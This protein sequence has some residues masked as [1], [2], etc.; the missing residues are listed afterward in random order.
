MKE[1]ISKN[2][3]PIAIVVAG[4]LVAVACFL[5]VQ[6]NPTTGEVDN[7][8]SLIQTEILSETAYSDQELEDLAKCLTESGAKFYGASWCGWCNKEKELFGQAVQYLPYV[9]C[10]DEATQGLTQV[11]QDKGIQ[12]FPTWEFNGVQSP[13]YKEAAVLAQMSGCQ[14]K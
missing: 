8:A 10:Y 11:C 2:A 3:T 4:L 7:T 12:G 1:L 13:G 6:K 14:I 9:E 5:S